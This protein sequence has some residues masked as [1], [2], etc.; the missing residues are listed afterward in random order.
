MVR[1]F[2]RTDR[3]RHQL[4][5]DIAEV[6]RRDIK[7]Y[8][9]VSVTITGVEISRDIKYATVYYTV[10]QADRERDRI[11]EILEKVRPVVQSEAGRRLGVRTIPV[12]RFV[13]DESIERSMRLGELFSQIENEREHGP[14]NHPQ[15]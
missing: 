7:G 11:A 8:D 13:F 12:L 10:M 2:E 5:R 14:E 4:A 3:I 6:L 9:L 15:D 1:S